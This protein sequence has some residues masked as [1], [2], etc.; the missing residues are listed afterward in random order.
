MS[1]E[2]SEYFLVRFNGKNYSTWAFQFQIF[3]KGKELWGHIDGTHPAPNSEKEK[4]KYVK[5]E[6]KDAKI[7]SWIL[8]SMESSIL[9]NLRPYKT[10]REMWD[11]LKNI[12][13]QSNTARRFQLEFELGQL[14]QRCM[15]IQ[16]F[17]SSFGNLSIQEFYSSFGNLWAEYT[18]IV[19]ASVPPEGTHQ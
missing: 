11:Y 13:N 7:M 5:W 12:Y 2:Q 10:S 14:S 9:L 3:T 17:Y 15:S 19:Y 18:D 16:E 6:V 8:G 1:L 4:E